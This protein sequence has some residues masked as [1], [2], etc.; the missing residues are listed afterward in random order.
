MTPGPSGRARVR[1][2]GRVRRVAARALALV[3]AA[4]LAPGCSAPE[5][6]PATVRQEPPYNATDVAWLRLA[7]ALHGRA[8]PM[9]ALAPERSRSRPLIGLAGRLAAAHETGRARLRTLLARA[10]QAGENPHAQH[11]M[12]GMPTSADLEAL[13]GLRGDAFDRR[14]A[15]LAG[16]YLDQLVLVAEGE[17]RSGGDAEVRRLAAGMARRHAAERAELRRSVPHGIN[18]WDFP[19]GRAKLISD[20]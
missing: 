19:P 6:G 11:D 3:V 15:R 1:P 4:L 2:A 12:P 13:R 16:A 20:Q 14:F 17:Q 18:G 8:L 5:D 10:G 7:E 9:L